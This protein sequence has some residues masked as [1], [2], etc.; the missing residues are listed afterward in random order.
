MSRNFELMRRAHERS[1]LTAAPPVLQTPLRP[2]RGREAR[3]EPSDWLHLTGVLRKHWKLSATFALT[4]ITVVGAITVFMRPVYE[5]EARLEVDPPGAEIFSLQ[6]GALGSNDSEFLETQAQK[7]RSD[8]LGMEVIRKLHLDQNPDLVRHGPTA[9]SSGGAATATTRE[10]AALRAFHQNL[11]I[12]RDA[13]SRLISVR[14]ASHDPRTAAQ[15]LN[16]LVDRFIEKSYEARHEAVMQ[17]SQWLSRQLDDI[18]T[19][20]E[21]SN[22]ALAEYQNSSGIADVDDKK[23]TFTE[24]MGELSRQLGQAQAERIQLESYL[25]GI[26][27]DGGT[28]L[29][30]IDTNPVVHAIEQKQAEVNAEL[31]RAR[32][33]YGPNHP[34]V[35]ELESQVAELRRQLTGQERGIVSN[36]QA[37]YAAAR[38][39]ERLLEGQTKDASRELTKMA[40]YNELKRDAQA[41]NELYNNLY[42]RVKEA[43]IAAESKSSN[44]RVVD[45]ARILDRPTR[46]N[47]ALD[48]GIATFVGLFGGIVLAFVK[49]GLMNTIHTPEDARRYTGA[50]GASI[51]PAIESCGRFL[52]GREAGAVGRLLRGH[53]S[54]VQRFVLERPHSPESEAVQGLRTSV[55]LSRPEAPP[56]VILVVSASLGEGKTTVATNLALALARNSRTCLVDADLRRPGIADAFNI[57]AERG[58]SDV[59]RSEITL[60]DVFICPPSAARI[61]LLP[62]GAANQ[63]ASVLF[64]TAKMAEVVSRLRST[65]EH[66]VIDTPPLLP[67]ADAR[68]ISPLADGVIV[69]GRSGVT[70][71]DALQRSME[72]LEEVHSAPI[73]EFV[74]NAADYTT[75]EYR[76]YR[77]YG[78]RNAS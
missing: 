59:L 38:K 77:Q 76:Y 41:N 18:R 26:R 22:R 32:V 34:K 51:V 12:K 55:L 53:R 24:Q 25:S 29:P 23:T 10:N 33:I 8:E 1:S 74:L 67:Y 52:P 72:L 27:R 69:V 49:E 56:R 11:T 2:V 58:L 65:F 62:A 15:V 4:V 39:R 19:K 16:T 66:V 31:S 47:R 42:A 35:R 21:E 73:L 37:G 3:E 70:T 43:G 68:A 71:R 50:L 9:T 20:M 7:L 36:V 57:Q 44:M 28:A 61:T 5:P 54:N 78:Y 6:N 48:L 75:P 40:R 13:T 14:Y 64:A 46:P 63:E 45:Q 30:Q 17:S 60:E